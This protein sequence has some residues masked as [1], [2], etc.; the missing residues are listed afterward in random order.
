MVNDE[1]GGGQALEN[2]FRVADE[3]LRKVERERDQARRER[4]KW[5][6][7]YLDTDE[8]LHKA[9]DERDQYK[10]SGDEWKECHADAVRERDEWKA[11]AEAAE[12]RTT[13]AVTRAD[14]EKS[15]LSRRWNTSGPDSQGFDIIHIQS[16]TDAVCDLFGVESEQATDPLLDKAQEFAALADWILT[17]RESVLLHTVARHVLGQEADQ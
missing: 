12:A 3:E 17:E 8:S 2:A 11:R 7:K 6:E 4:D 13:P 16:A 15:I 9:R 14:I 1:W 5:E 10:R